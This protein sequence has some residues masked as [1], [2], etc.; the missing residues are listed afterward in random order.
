LLAVVDLVLQMAMGVVLTASVLRWD[1][2]RLPPERLARAWNVASFWSA[3]VGFGPLCLVVHFI[4]T[5]R[6]LAGALLGL[7]FALAVL[8]ALGAAAEVAALVL[9]PDPP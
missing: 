1:M 2:R 3:V 9:G 4:R 7:A 6:S 5:R 8:L